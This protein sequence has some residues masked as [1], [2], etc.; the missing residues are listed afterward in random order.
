ML[1]SSVHQVGRTPHLLV[2]LSK[3][4]LSCVVQASLV[5][6]HKQL[7]KPAANTDLSHM[8]VII[9]NHFHSLPAQLSTCQHAAG[10]L[11]IPQEALYKKNVLITR[12]RFRPF[13]LLH[14][15]MLIGAASQFFC[16]PDGTGVLSSQDFVGESGDAYTECVYRDDTLVLLELTTRDMME[17]CVLHPC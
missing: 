1:L 8:S 13:T 7:L 14:N 17:V 15:D 16:D 5:A 3:F 12:G 6:Q 4:F 10:N 11:Q 9:R 2:H